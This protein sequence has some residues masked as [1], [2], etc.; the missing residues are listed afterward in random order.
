MAQ[1]TDRGAAIPAEVPARL[2]SRLQ[3]ALQIAAQLDDQHLPGALDRIQLRTQDQLREMDQLHLNEAAE[4]LT[5][6]ARH[7][8]A[9][10]ERSAGFPRALR[11]R[12]A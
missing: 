8:A 12:S 7:G 2:Q 3:A 10:S 9:G 4:I 11:S 6:V 1:L 5:Q